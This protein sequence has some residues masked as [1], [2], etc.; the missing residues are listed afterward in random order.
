MTINMSEAYMNQHHAHLSTGF[1]LNG[2]MYSRIIPGTDL[3]IDNSDPTYVFLDYNMPIERDVNIVD[4]LI[5]FYGRVTTFRCRY[6]RQLTVSGN[7]TVTDDPEVDPFVANGFLQ[8]DM[9]A[10]TNQGTNGQRTSVTIT[11]QHGLNLATNVQ[12]CTITYDNMPGDAIYPIHNFED[13]V[14]LDNRIESTFSVPNGNSTVI[15][16]DWRTFHFNSGNQN[17]EQQNHD[18]NCLIHADETLSVNAPL[19]NC[20]C[21][22]PTECAANK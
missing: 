18:I 9:V 5:V 11:A 8:Y 14:C 12:K 6:P 19:P 16:L 22:T 4:D 10:R 1:D 7:V 20:D 17:Q 13:A 21:Y 3:S 2:N 15:T